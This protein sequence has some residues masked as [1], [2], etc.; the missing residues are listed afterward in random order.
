MRLIFFRVCANFICNKEKRKKFKKKYIIYKIMLTRKINIREAVKSLINFIKVYNCLNF[1]LR[2]EQ[3]LLC[4]KC[5]CF[6]NKIK[7]ICFFTCNYE[8]N[9]LDCNHFRG[10]GDV[11]VCQKGQTDILLFRDF[12]LNYRDNNN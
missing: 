11:F 8:K 1:G 4:Y 2:A 3:W 9:S 7:I 6:F 5:M 12:A 10:Y